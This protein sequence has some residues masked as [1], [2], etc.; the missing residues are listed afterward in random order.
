MR[1]D[2]LDDSMIMRSF[3]VGGFCPMISGPKEER[4]R[5]VDRLSALQQPVIVFQEAIEHSR[6][7]LCVIRQDDY[8]GGRLIADH[9]LARRV[10]S[11][12]V[13]VPRQ[14]WPAIEYRVAGLA[15]GLAKDPS[16]AVAIIESASE[17]FGDVQAALARYL[18]DHPVPGA[19]FG[20]NDA[21][22]TAALLLLLDRGCRVP[23]DVKVVGFNGFEIHRYSRPQL[24]TG[25]SLPMRWASE[26]GERCFTALK[27]ATF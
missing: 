24:T 26:P 22:A 5:I 9:L 8:G 16:V 4:L 1:G 15:D 18:Q 20:T 2:Q 7:D 10:S 6:P 23:E 17:S 11:Y 3:E 14:G 21:I 25:L 27:L 19:V 12:L 13:M